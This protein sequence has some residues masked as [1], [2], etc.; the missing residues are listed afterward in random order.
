[1]RNLSKDERNDEAC[2]AF[3]GGKPSQWEFFLPATEVG[4][5]LQIQKLETSYH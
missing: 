4:P 1:M 5:V 2:F 3:L